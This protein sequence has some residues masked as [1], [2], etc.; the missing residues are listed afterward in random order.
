MP[1]PSPVTRTPPNAISVSPSATARPSRP[2]SFNDSTFQSNKNTTVATVRP[3]NGV[4][5]QA[6]KKDIITF[7]ASM[8]PPPSTVDKFAIVETSKPPV[9]PQV[10]DVGTGSD[11]T[12]KTPKPEKYVRGKVDIVIGRE[13]V[14]VSGKDS[15]SGTPT[16]NDGTG[17]GTEYRNVIGGR[18]RSDP[19]NA[20][21]MSAAT[22]DFH[23]MMRYSGMAF[24]GVS[25]ALLLF[26]QFLSLDPALLPKWE[27]NRAWAPNTW[28]F[29]LYI[30]YLQ[31]LASTSQLSLIKA[32]YFMWDFT[33]AYSWT[34][35]LMQTGYTGS[36]SMASDADGI[37]SKPRRL[38]TILIGGVVAY[39]DR[40]GIKEQSILVQT[41]ICIAVLAAVVVVVFFLATIFA[42]RRAEHYGDTRSTD[43]MIEESTRVHKL[44][45]VSAR[46][47]GMGVV[48]WFTA[49]YPLSAFA[50]FEIT[51]QVTSDD[52]STGPLVLAIFALLI[53]CCVS[54]AIIMRL[55][56]SKDNKEMQDIHTRAIWGPLAAHCHYGMRLFFFFAALAQ[57]VSGILVG[58][59]DAEPGQVLGSIAVLVVYLVLVFVLKPFTSRLATAMTFVVGVVKIVNTGLSLAF[60]YSNNNLSPPARRSCAEALIGINTIV[61]VVWFVRHIGM[62]LAYLRVYATSSGDS[63]H[64]KW[65]SPSQAVGIEPVPTEH[66]L[67]TYPSSRQGYGYGNGGDATPTDVRVMKQSVSSMDSYYDSQPMRAHDL[68]A[69]GEQVSTPEMKR[70]GVSVVM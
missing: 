60:L 37:A 21:Q 47:L 66:M 39:A 22:A 2:V 68:A 65:T 53:V 61:I 18:M 67:P 4:D 46:I 14:V 10:F 15:S 9:A 44:R 31:Q 20:N 1:S 19:V 17:T 11:R 23:D 49:L 34:N 70:R 40:L 56:W 12:E 59:T 45:N 43:I 62:F 27:S 52:I 7:N 38:T 16:A 64:E 32:P 3:A 51:M 8:S 36:K 63:D 54:L 5:D 35:F 55:V 26:F 24:A 28:E 33:D 29:V 57:I 25:V 58:S 69:L 13:D 48:L 42:K 6:T 41:M 30:G 50:S